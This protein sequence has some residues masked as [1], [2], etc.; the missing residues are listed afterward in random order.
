MNGKGEVEDDVFT[1]VG[2]GMKIGIL[3]NHDEP[4][5]RDGRYQ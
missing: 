4:R 5:N 3:L 1:P 2:R